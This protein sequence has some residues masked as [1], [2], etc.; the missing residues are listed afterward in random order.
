[1]SIFRKEALEAR[2]A[3]EDGTALIV[4]PPWTGTLFIGIGVLLLGFIAWSIFGR[5]PVTERGKAILQPEGGPRPLVSTVSGRVLSIRV[6]NGQAVKAGDIILEIEAPSVAAPA[7]L[8]ERDKAL[9]GGDL[10][11]LAAEEDRIYREQKRRIEERLRSAREQ[12]TSLEKSLEMQAKK[13]VASERLF[14]DQ[15]LSSIQAD[16]AREGMEALRRQHQQ[17]KQAIAGLIQESATLEAQSADRSLQRRRDLDRV[18]ANAT[19]QALAQAQTVVVAAVD[20]VVEGLQANRGDSVQVADELGRVIPMSAPLEVVAYLSEKHQAFAKEGGVAFVE[21]D[22]LP[23]GEFGSAKARIKRIARGTASSREMQTTLG[24]QA[25]PAEGPMVRV[26]LDLLDWEP[27]RKAGVTLQPGMRAQV[28]FMVRKQSL[29]SLMVAPFR[30]W[31][32]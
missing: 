18:D 24:V 20:G 11:R 13:V 22:Q 5:V 25:P 7:L 26:E 4:A 12:L 21:I 29:F 19:G 14:K 2:Q 1:M 32:D 28:R 31:L 30:R 6:R 3:R 9:A 27:A 23:Y 16:E 17:A 15:L 10:S 8:A